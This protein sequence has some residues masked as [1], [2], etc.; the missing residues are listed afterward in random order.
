M[1]SENVKVLKLKE[2]GLI[3]QIKDRVGE[4]NDIARQLSLIEGELAD[5]RGEQRHLN[6][7]I[8]L[9]EN[10]VTI[11]K[12]AR[13]PRAKNSEKKTEKKKAEQPDVTSEEFIENM[14]TEDAQALLA[15]IQQC[16]VE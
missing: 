7:R 5:L 12:P 15:K 9:L 4:R 6:T 2:A 16:L 10:E 13:G 11:C 3:K 1:L 8:W 14:S